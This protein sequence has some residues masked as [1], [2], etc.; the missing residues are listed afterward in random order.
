MN[1]KLKDLF[2]S[3][4]K[5]LKKK[6]IVVSSDQFNI[7]DISKDND[8]SITSKQW[9]RCPKAKKYAMEMTTKELEQAVEGM[10]H[11]LNTLQSRSGKN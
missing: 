11:N 2:S 10:Y 1:D 4:M 8:T 7:S 6:Y 9:D 5:E 3:T